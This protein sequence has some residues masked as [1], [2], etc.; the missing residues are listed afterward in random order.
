MPMLTFYI[1]RKK[2]LPADR[3][4]AHAGRCAGPAQRRPEQQIVKNLPS[5]IKNS[6]TPE[7]HN[8][9]QHHL[10]E[11]EGHVRRLEQIFQMQKQ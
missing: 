7:L 1:S 5:T 2:D 3:L 10:G 11:T 4:W 8:A 6:D 9:F